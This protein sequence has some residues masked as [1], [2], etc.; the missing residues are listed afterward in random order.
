MPATAALPF[1]MPATPGEAI[2][3][4]KELA[5]RVIQ[6]DDFGAVTRIAGIDIGFED[7]GATVRAAVVVLGFPDLQR[8]ESAV[9][10][11]PTE[12]PYIPGL[13]SFREIPAALDALAQI[14]RPP[15]LI[16]YD[17][18]G[19]AHPRRCGIASHMGLVT[20]IPSIGVAKSRLCGRFEAPAAQRGAHTPLIHKNET[21]GVALTTRP[22][23][24]PVFVS[25]GHRVSLASAIAW[26]MACTGRW[27]LPETTRAAHKLASEWR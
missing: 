19:R 16:L 1:L 12:F 25:C 22:G 3:Q 2:A 4:Q 10:R 24:K 23:Y 26:T 8:L 27:R 14:G 18:Q 9:A 6:H 5:G 11:R 15:D 17:G 7:E 21:I 20:G 13:L